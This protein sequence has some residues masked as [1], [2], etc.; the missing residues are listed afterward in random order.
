[1]KRTGFSFFLAAYVLFFKAVLFA[2]EPAV[3]YETDFD[4]LA[5]GATQYDP[6][7]PEQDGWFLAGA[8]DFGY[9]EIQDEF[10]NPGRALHEHADR[11]AGSW[12]QTI[13]KRFLAPPDLSIYPQVTLEVDFYA[14]TSNLE[15]R[16]SYIAALEVFGGPHPGYYMIGFSV[17][18]GNGDVKGEAGLRVNLSCFNGS[19]NN[20]SVPLT[21]GYNLAWETW[22]HVRIVIDQSADSYVSLTVNEQTQTLDGYVLPRSNDEGIWKRGQLMESIQTLIVP[23]DDFGE[24][25][26]DDIYWDN[27]ALH[28]QCTLQADLTGDCKVNMED[29]AILAAEWLMGV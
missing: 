25:S 23:V 15:G 11:N 8:A 28:G 6:G 22:H 26:D 1:M 13:D 24:S 27:L 29:L 3:F 4:L 5:L 21:I 19:D 18:S 7:H 12:G 10:A 9:G 16:N 2:G 14:T 20:E 17:T